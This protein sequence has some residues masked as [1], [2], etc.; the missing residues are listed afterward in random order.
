[1]QVLAQKETS[2]KDLGCYQLDGEN[3]LKSLDD[4]LKALQEMSK[5]LADG[6][7]KLPQEAVIKVEEAKPVVPTP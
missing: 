5:G 4:K 1:M 6:T 7:F 2:E 3:Y